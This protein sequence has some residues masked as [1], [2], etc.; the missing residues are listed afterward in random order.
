MPTIV[1]KKVAAKKVVISKAKPAKSATA[2]KKKLIEAPKSKPVQVEVIKGEPVKRLLITQPK[3]VEGDR[4]PYFE[5]AKRLNNPIF[6]IKIEAKT[7]ENIFR[8]AKNFE[9]VLV[10][11][12]SWM[13]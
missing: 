12:Q 2:K 4:S 8:E 6:E 13:G 10:A 7:L 11:I 9:M 3:P 5:I 1:K